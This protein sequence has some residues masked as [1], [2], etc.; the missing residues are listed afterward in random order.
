MMRPPTIDQICLS[1]TPRNSIQHYWLDICSTGLSQPLQIPVIVARGNNDKPVLGIT[2][3]IHG[4][5]INGIAAIHGIM[6]NI[7][8][9]ALEGSIIAIPVCNVPS[10]VRRRRRFPN[11]EDL[12]RIM[13]GNPT[14]NISGIYAHH[15]HDKVLTKLDYL[16][17]LHTASFGRVNSFYVRANMNSKTIRTMAKLQNPGIILHNEPTVG[18]LRHAAEE[19]GLP[20]ITVELGDPNIFQQPFIDKGINGI[21]N[22]LDHL[23]MLDK[24]DDTEDTVVKPII[25]KDSYWIYAADGGLLTVHPELYEKVEKGQ[26]IATLT[27]VFGSEL[28]QYKAPEDGIVIGKSNSPVGEAG[29]RILHLGL[30]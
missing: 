26:L 24:D 10:F 11:H 4:N 25:C 2:A 6:E 18:T 12:N 23:H 30:Y 22:M 13:P 9:H 5:E 8:I 15:F 14:G 1:D 17:D 21:H 28:Q 16:I 7:D 29:A 27:D 3:A 20:A 19:L